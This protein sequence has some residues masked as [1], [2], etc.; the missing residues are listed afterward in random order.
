MISNQYPEIRAGAA[1]ALGQLRDEAALEVL[2]ASFDAYEEGIRIE[3]ARA[4]AKLAI[5]FTPQIV[6]ALP[7]SEPTKRAGIAW[8]LSQSA[9]F[10]VE[11]LLRNQN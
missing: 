8:V 6:A 3:A 5:E 9:Q 2:I 4:L 1:W 11:Q 7:Q 10:T